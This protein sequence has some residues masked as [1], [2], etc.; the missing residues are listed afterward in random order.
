VSSIMPCRY[1]TLQ[2]VLIAFKKTGVQLVEFNGKNFL[3]ADCPDDPGIFYFV[4]KLVR[5]FNVSLDSALDL[6]FY[7]MIVFSSILAI[8]GFFS[9]SKSWLFRI[10]A[11]LSVLGFWFFVPRSA[12]DVYLVNA[13]IIFAVVP[14][15]LY[16]FRAGYGK[17]LCIFLFFSGVLIGYANLIRSFSGLPVLLFLLLGLFFYFKGT[18]RQKG[19]LFFVLL[20]GL[21]IPK[22]HFASLNQA[23]RDFLGSKNNALVEGHHLWHNVYAG[24]GF[25]SNEFGIVSND[26][27]IAEKVYENHPDVVYPTKAYNAAARKDIF[28]LIKKHPSFVVR[29]LFAKLGVVFYF[30]L[31][32]ANLGLLAAFF[33]RKPWI[34][35]LMFWVGIMVSSIP[36]FIAIPGR[37]YL[38]GMLAFAMVYGLVSIGYAIEKG[39]LLVLRSPASRAK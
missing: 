23:K 9:L 2:N 39:V 21:S 20:V 22:L 4:P 15:A 3:P 30:L 32:F 12:F 8:I 10:Y 7:S 36:G 27:A 35:E 18:W 33:Y 11:S 26:K 16:V 6:F 13:A 19:I 28:Q 24:F 38:L 14:L 5:L 25:L 31:L 17:F 34:L 37:V 29:T 1:E